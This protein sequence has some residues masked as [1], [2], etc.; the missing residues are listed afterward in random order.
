MDKGPKAEI[1]NWNLSRLNLSF[2][3]DI[4]ERKYPL[5]DSLEKSVKLN[6]TSVNKE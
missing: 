1:T 2:I 4:P 3:F 5:S 6:L